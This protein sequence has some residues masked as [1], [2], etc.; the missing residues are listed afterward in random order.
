[1]MILIPVLAL[2]VVSN[3][4]IGLQETEASLPKG[5]PVFESETGG[6]VVKFQDGDITCYSLRIGGVGVALSCVNNK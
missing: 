1:M 3:L 6:K 4:R 2:L 5:V